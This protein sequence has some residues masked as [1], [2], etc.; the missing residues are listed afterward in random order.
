MKFLDLFAGIGGFRTGMERAGHVCVGHIE[1]DKYA[2]K[3]YESIYSKGREEDYAKEFNGWD[4][5]T[6]YGR[7][8]PA[9][10]IWTFGAPCQDFSIAGKRAG[11]KGNRSNLVQEVFRLFRE[12]TEENRPRYLI[13][14]N[15]KGMFSSNNGRDFLAILLEMESLGF[16]IEWQLLNSKHFG[17]PQNRERVFIIGHLGNGRSREIFPIG[18]TSGTTNNP[19]EIIQVAQYDTPTRENSN[20]FRTYSPEGVGAALSTMGGGGLEPCV[21]V[22]EATKKGYDIAEVGDSINFEQPNSKTRRGRVGKGVAN[23]LTSV[24]KDN[25]VVTK[26][27]YRIRKLLPIECWR[28]QGFTDEQF[29]KAQDAGVSNSQLYKQAGNSV[30]VNVIEAIAERLK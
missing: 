1:N 29:Y 27:S 19:N 10:D 7:D 3:S 14:E 5:T 17:V 30:T 26:P 20:R 18:G 15:V 24:Q 16:D 2:Q 9:A 13:Y 23:T 22:R 6:V 21:M 4:I 25:L 11:L 12:T 28:L 8:L